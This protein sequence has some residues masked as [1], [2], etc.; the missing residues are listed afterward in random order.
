MIVARNEFAIKPGLTEQALAF[1]KERAAGSDVP[2][3]I[4]VDEAGPTFTVAVEMEYESMAERERLSAEQQ[5]TPESA[6]LF[7]KW[8]AFL[9]GPG[10]R[11]LWRLVE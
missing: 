11:E 10:C 2:I 8:C 5:A 6:A 4:Y 3:R 1:L 9:R 7:E